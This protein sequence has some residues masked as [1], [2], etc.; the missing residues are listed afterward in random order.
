VLVEQVD[1]VG[2]EVAQA[3]VGDL[4]DVLNA[5]WTVDGAPAQVLALVSTAA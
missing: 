3:V 2:A 5:P 1:V 4:E